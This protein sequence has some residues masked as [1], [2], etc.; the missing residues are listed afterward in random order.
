LLVFVSHLSQKKDTYIYR[1]E[2][3]KLLRIIPTR[4]PYKDKHSLN[5]IAL[6]PDNQYLAASYK[7]DYYNHGDFFFP[8]FPK[9][10]FGH[11]RIWNIE[12]GRQIATLRGHWMGTNTITFSPDG[13]L[14]ASTGKEDNQIRFWCMPP[15]SCFFW[16]MG[17]A[18]LAAF[19]YR[20]RAYLIGWI[21]R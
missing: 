2:N 3:G 4:E 15:Y 11:I 12:N 20:Q 8:S 6:S 19:V 14:L 17:I 9:A 13:K 7:I 16:L 21:N 1:V 10:F 5:D 18:G